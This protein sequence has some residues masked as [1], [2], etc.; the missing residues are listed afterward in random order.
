LQLG[1]QIVGLPLCFAQVEHKVWA[2]WHGCDAQY[3]YH[4]DITQIRLHESSFDF[5]GLI[6][7]G[8]R[9]FYS[10]QAVQDVPFGFECQLASRFAAVI[11]P[12]YLCKPGQIMKKI[13]PDF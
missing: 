11:I 13:P 10:Y 5:I 8:R 6:K 7:K 2:L 1:S 9:K 12:F 3:L 4:S